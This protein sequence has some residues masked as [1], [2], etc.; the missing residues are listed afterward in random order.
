MSADP[1]QEIV[2]FYVSMDK[3]LVMNI[4]NSTNHLYICRTKI[5]NSGIVAMVTIG[6]NRIVVPTYSVFHWVVTTLEYQC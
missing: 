2:W 3:V 6:A 1:H 4:L 5:S